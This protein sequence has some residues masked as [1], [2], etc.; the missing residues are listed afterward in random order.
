MFVMRSTDGEVLSPKHLRDL[1]AKH[2]EAYEMR[3]REVVRENAHLPVK[4]LPGVEELFHE[5][6]GRTVE[7][8]GRL[9]AESRAAG[10]NIEFAAIE[11]YV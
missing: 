8:L 4:E 3:R 2:H 9:V 7:D 5:A 11:K 10:S 6:W 1:A